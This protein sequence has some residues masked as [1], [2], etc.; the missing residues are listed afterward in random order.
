MVVKSAWSNQ[1]TIYE[2]IAEKAGKVR[3]WLAKL[4]IEFHRDSS[5]NGCA[6][7]IPCSTA[8]SGE[9][10]SNLFTLDARLTEKISWSSNFLVSNGE[11]GFAQV[12]RALGWTGDDRK[13][14]DLSSARASPIRDWVKRTSEYVFNPYVVLVMVF[15]AM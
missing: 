1:G 3:A 11:F 13:R 10:R 8:Y 12:E 14:L 15:L 2:E 5:F 4:G 6:D 9:N 7:H